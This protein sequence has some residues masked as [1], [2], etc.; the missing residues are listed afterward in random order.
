MDSYFTDIINNNS[1]LNSVKS[2][3]RRNIHSLSYLIDYK[4]SQSDCIKLGIA[5]EKVLSDIIFNETE[6]ICIKSK[7]IKGVKEKDHLFIDH[8]Y[9]IIY[10]AEIK[11][12]LYLDTEKTKATIKKCKK[13]KEELKEKYKGYIIKTHLVGGRYVNKSKFH[14]VIIN[15][16]K[17]FDDVY[18]IDEYFQ[19]LCVPFQFENEF[20]Y[21][22][23][24]NLIAKKIIN[25][26]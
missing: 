13:I 1:Y 2:N 21:K 19:S 6:L 20:N 22:K 12:N 25:N 26:S 18:S 23:F 4:L 24:L 16:Y 8:Y 17:D 11:S 9:N 15:K 7:N 5:L 10:Y 3:K 14:K